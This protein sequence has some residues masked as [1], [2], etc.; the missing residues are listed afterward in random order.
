M[1]DLQDLI[2]SKVR[3]LKVLSFSHIEKAEH[4]D[5]M[6]N[7]YMY[8]CLCDCGQETLVNRFHLK[9][10]DSASATWSCGCYQKAQSLKG[11]EKQRGKPRPQ[12]QKPNGQSIFNTV[13]AAYKKGAEKRN[14]TFLLSEK[15]FEELT[16]QNCY[17]CEAVPRLMTKDS[18]HVTRSMN[19]VDR[20]DPNQGYSADN[21]VPCCKTCNYMKLASSKEAFLAQVH[22]IATTHPLSKKLIYLVTGAPGAGKSW[23][24]GQLP[25]RFQ[26]IDSDKVSKAKLVDEI[27]KSDKIPVVALTIG[28]STF[29]SRN[30]Q[31]DVKLFVIEE[32][33][34]IIEARLLQR[35]GKVTPTIAK[36]IKRMKSLANEADAV[37]TS[38][39]IRDLFWVGE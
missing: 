20:V 28:I 5:R 13:F 2:G 6:R 3:M 30:P 23:V 26:A 37:G 14:F 22:K 32:D 21:C 29:I 1:L 35:N 11:H 12:V 9:Q 38:D 17:Y 34:C 4:A 27:Q 24:L 25:E 36:R 8:W 39:E 19:G 16:K 7:K 31:F 10:K 18:G 33:E 15:E